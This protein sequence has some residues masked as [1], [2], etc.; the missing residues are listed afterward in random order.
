MSSRTRLGRESGYLAS[1]EDEWPERR[2]W[3]RDEVDEEDGADDE[4]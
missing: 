1:V 3:V 4:G 2:P